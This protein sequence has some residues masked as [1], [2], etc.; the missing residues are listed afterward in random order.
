MSIHVLKKINLEKIINLPG[1]DFGSTV[2]IEAQ[3]LKHFKI[4]ISLKGFIADLHSIQGRPETTK[5]SNF[6][7]I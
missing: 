4:Q 1:F 5:L 2:R 3:C 6:D 7:A